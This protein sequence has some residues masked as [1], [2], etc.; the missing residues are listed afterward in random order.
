MEVPIENIQRSLNLFSLFA[1]RGEL[2]SLFLHN[3]VKGSFNYPELLNIL[4]FWILVGTCSSYLFNR[5]FAVSHC[6]SFGTIPWVLWI[7]NVASLMEWDLKFFLLVLILRKFIV[8]LQI[9]LF[10]CWNSWLTTFTSLIFIIYF[11]YH[12]IIIYI[13]RLSILLLNLS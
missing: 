11:Y 1:R 9:F 3:L 13:I 7:G 5:H 12:T 2:N 10:F 4:D 8:L 6:T